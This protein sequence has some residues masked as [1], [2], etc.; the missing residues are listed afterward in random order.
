[1]SNGSTFAF[2]VLWRCFLLCRLLF[3]FRLQW[4]IEDI[5]LATR[6]QAHTQKRQNCQRVKESVGC[7]MRC[8]RGVGVGCC[9]VQCNAV[10][11]LTFFF[12]PLLYSGKGCFRDDRAAVVFFFPFLLHSLRG[13]LAIVPFC[14][15]SPYS[16]RSVADVCGCVVHVGL[17]TD[18]MQ[19]VDHGE[20]AVRVCSWVRS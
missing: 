10:L 17:W 3:F 9:T 8:F 4:T 2:F 14:S 15:L 7:L 16:Q 12:P 13:G 20:C 5:A 18:I 19:S 1:M 11:C 6:T